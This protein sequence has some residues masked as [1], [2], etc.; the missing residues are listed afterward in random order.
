M[1]TILTNEQRLALDE[2][3]EGIEVEDPQTQKKYVLTDAALHHRAMQA[4]H[5]QEDRDAIQ[6]GIEDMK[7]GRVEPY[8]EVSRRLRAHLR[9]KFGACT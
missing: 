7:A 5:R 8:S 9:E 1:K 2:Q 3:P 4:L 6:A